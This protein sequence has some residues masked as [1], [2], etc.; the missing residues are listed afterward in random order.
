MTISPPTKVKT[1]H[2]VSLDI[3]ASGI[4]SLYLAID[5]VWQNEAFFESLTT[6]KEVCKQCGN[7]SALIMKYNDNSAKWICTLKPYGIKGYEWFLTGSDFSLKIGNWIEP[8]SRP[9]IIVQIHS[10]VLWRLGVKQ[11]IGLLI[12]ILTAQNA[13]IQTIKPSRVDL[14][15]DTLWPKNLWEMNLINYSVTRSNYA[16][17]H[18]NNLTLTGLSIGKGTVSA[19]LYD[20]PL[21]ITQKSKKFW[22]YDVW[23]V[24]SVPEEF[25]IIRIEFQLRR[26]ALKDLGIEVLEDL[27]SHLDNLWAYCTKN[28]LKFQD[29]PGAHHT[30]RNTFKWWQ[31]IQNGFLGV[32]NPTPLI[33]CKAINSKMDQLLAQTLGTMASLEALHCEKAMLDIDEEISFSK[34]LKD[35]RELAQK[36][37]INDF[38]FSIGVQDK[39]SKHHRA[40]RKMYKAKQM[41]TVLGHPSH[42][43]P[44]KIGE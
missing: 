7:D 39:R 28:W 41:R 15:L 35:V 40:V 21:E 42:F 3:L 14:C 9:S 37:G 36:K 11:S 16:S 12:E 27:M 2:S 6:M 44:K 18:L 17:P 43:H 1:Y 25:N 33:W 22:M 13:K 8:I 34:A 4:D 19:R 29:N 5:V 26:E 23:G 24:E 20:K 31:E 32:Q 30:Q 38:N 10:E